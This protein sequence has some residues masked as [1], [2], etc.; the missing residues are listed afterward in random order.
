MLAR[1]GIAVSREVVIEEGVAVFGGVVAV[2]VVSCAEDVWNLTVQTLHQSGERLPLLAAEKREAVGGEQPLV[3][4]IDQ[5]TSEE[6]LLD[7]Q[8]VHIV[9]NPSVHDIDNAMIAWTFRICLHIGNHNH[10]P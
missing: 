8:S 1:H 9:N 2:V 4:A 6:N 5:I 3:V 7:S 10:C